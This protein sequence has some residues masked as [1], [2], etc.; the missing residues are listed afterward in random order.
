MHV[1][2][3]TFSRPGR[4]CKLAQLK[5]ECSHGETARQLLL[6]VCHILVY[7]DPH[8][9]RITFFPS[10]LT[11]VSYLGVSFTRSPKFRMGAK[12]QRGLLTSP[13]EIR[14]RQ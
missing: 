4:K 5:L 12:V 6:S 8:L 11:L 2:C 14:Y 13:L 10:K 7:E 1:S 3:R 9:G